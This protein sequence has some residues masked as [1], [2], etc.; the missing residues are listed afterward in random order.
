MAAPWSTAWSTTLLHNVISG[1]TDLAGGRRDRES[2]FDSF[3]GA[4]GS[5]V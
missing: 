3:Q 2:C 5:L 4:D 1:D